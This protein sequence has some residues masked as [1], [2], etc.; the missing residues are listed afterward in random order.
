MG[1]EILEKMLAREQELRMSQET[2]AK[3]REAEERS[4]TDWIEVTVQLQR[5]VSEFKN[6]RQRIGARI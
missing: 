5:Q 6:R 3:Y 1:E 2:Q 4:D